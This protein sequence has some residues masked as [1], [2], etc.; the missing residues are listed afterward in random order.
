[1]Y[2]YTKPEIGNE[3]FVNSNFEGELH[4]NPTL[5]LMDGVLHI[6]TVKQ[7]DTD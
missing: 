2:D 3:V 5:L 4:S 1:M 7:N 6:L